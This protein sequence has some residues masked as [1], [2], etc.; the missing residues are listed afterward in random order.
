[1]SGLPRSTCHEWRTYV[2]T[3]SKTRPCPPSSRRKSTGDEAGRGDDRRRR[4]KRRRLPEVVEE[5]AADER[6]AERDA[7]EEVLNALRAAEDVVG[8]QVGVEAAV[9]GLV[10]VVGE[11]EREDE[12][13]RRPQVRHEGHQREAEAHR[14]DRDGHE[15]PAPAER[16]VERVAPGADHERQGQARRRPRRRARRRST[17]SSSCTGP[18]PAAGRR[19]SWSATRRARARRR[20]AWRSSRRSSRAQRAAA[21][22]GMSPP[23]TT[24]M[25]VR[26]ARAT[27]SSPS[28]SWPSTHPVR[29]SSIPP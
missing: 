16:R 23:Q 11:E 14:A 6:A 20:R 10:D 7:A 13:R 27:S 12:Q 19:R 26:S 17:T 25:T 9:R 1:M 28:G 4:E 18:A 2:V 8:Q 24:S 15:R 3:P 22:R 29:I 5:A 21:S